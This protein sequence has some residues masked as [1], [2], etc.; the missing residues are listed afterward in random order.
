MNKGQLTSVAGV[1][2]V[3]SLRLCLPLYVC[4][5]GDREPGLVWLVVGLDLCVLHAPS[6]E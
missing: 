2:G 5:W 4:L 6:V 1:A 3:F